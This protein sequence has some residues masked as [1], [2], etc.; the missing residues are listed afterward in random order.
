MRIFILV[1]VAVSIGG[2]ALAQ[3]SQPIDPR[4]ATPAIIA[5]QAELA[6]RD[7]Q[8]KALMEDMT[9]REKEWSAYSKP[10]WQSSDK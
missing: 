9:R 7:A 8:I 3:T 4:V 10:L 6:L 1:A 2:A 5:L